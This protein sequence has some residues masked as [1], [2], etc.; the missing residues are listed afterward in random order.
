M[1][2]LAAAAALPAGLQELATIGSRKVERVV[3]VRK[4][5]GRRLVL[6]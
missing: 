1:A 6:V 2:R 5:A 3:P 4:R